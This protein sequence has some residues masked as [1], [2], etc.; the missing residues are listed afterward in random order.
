MCDELL[1]PA[2][3]LPGEVPEPVGKPQGMYHLVKVALVRFFT[4]EQKEMCIRD[5][6]TAFQKM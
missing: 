1:L 5:R 4:V 2:G 6:S 3:Q